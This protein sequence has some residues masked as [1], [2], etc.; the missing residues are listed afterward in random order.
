MKVLFV[1]LSS[2]GDL[3][4]ALPALS[5]AKAAI[6][7]ISFDWAVEESF[8]EV[9][10]WHNAVTQVITTAHRRWR[11]EIWKSLTNK[12]LISFAKKLRANQ[13]DVIIDG[14]S[15]FKSA[16]VTRLAK[17]LRCGYDRDSV[18]EYIAH[19]AYQKKIFVPKKE[20]AITRLRMLCAEIL[21]YPYQNTAP[22]FGIDVQRLKRPQIKLPEKFLL[23]VHNASWRTKL[24]PEIYWAALL[25]KVTAAGYS[26]LLPSGNEEEQRRAK[27]LAHIHANIIALPRLGLSETTYIIS[28]AKGAVCCDT[29]LGHIVAAVG[30]PAVNL[31]GPTDS[32][33]IGATGKSQIHLQADFPCAPCYEKTC[34]FENNVPEWPPCFGQLTPDRVWEKL[35]ELGI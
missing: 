15:N 2:M 20:H 10:T 28:Q 29:G 18:R 7:N 6:P 14:Q 27:K 33:L 32:S 13:Y 4:H 35:K 9:A 17:G 30:I 22:D 25:K 26:V 12:E 3:L 8:A 31:Y 1:K 21:G 34:Q 24:W 16:I 19:F 5:D 23:F 11:W